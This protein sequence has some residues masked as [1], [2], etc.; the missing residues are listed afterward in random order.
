[1]RSVG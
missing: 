1:P